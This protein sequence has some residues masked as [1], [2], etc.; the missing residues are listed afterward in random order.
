MEKCYDLTLLLDKKYNST[1]KVRNYVALMLGSMRINKHGRIKFE[2]I[3][4]LAYGING[5]E[6]AACCLTTITV[7][8][9]MVVRLQ[10]TMIHDPNILRHLIIEVPF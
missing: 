8:P 4:R 9:D 3:Q 1:R 5:N 7:E 10:Q 6:E 2:G